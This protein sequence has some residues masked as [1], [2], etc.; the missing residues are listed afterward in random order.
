MKWY[1]FGVWLLVACGI[2]EPAGAGQPDVS[3]SPELRKKDAGVNDAGRADAGAPHASDAGDPHAS[4]AGSFGGP[5]V[6]TVVFENHDYAEVVGSSDAPYFNELIAKYG[7]ATN[8]TDCNIHPSLP[9]YLCMIS[10]APQF[11]GGSD[12]LPTNAPF[13]VK[14]KHLGSQLLAA[15]M[16]FRSYQESMGTACT[17]SS[18]GKYA[19]KHDPF[20]YFADVQSGPN[21]V[22]AETNVDYSQLAPDL[23]T[24]R[25]RYYFITPNLTNDGHDPLFDPRA[26]LRQSDTWARAEIGQI[27]QSDAYKN[28]GILFITW[29]EGEGRNGRSADQVPMIIVS[30]KI[31]SPGFRSAAAYSHLSY[32]ATVEDLLGLPRLPPVSTTPAMGEFIRR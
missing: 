14:A 26:A 20:L 3:V 12:P 22:C 31:V 17:L 10:G 8:Y 15:N 13:P 11:G 5:V 27:L 30:E 1:V 19:P 21:G 28:G 23:K 24:N 18:S 16:P 4:D 7:L 6:F 29:D 2:D 32:L 9:N 25:N